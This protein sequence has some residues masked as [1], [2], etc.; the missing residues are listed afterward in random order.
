MRNITLFTRMA[1]YDTKKSYFQEN[2]INI[3]KKQILFCD[4]PKTYI[5]LFSD[6]IGENEIMKSLNKH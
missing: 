6:T 4:F 2:T 5:L 1:H 3:A